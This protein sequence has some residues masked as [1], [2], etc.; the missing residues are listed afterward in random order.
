MT[1]P[2]S[3]D[4]QITTTTDSIIFPDG[5]VGCQ[6]WKNF[7]LLT[8]D[9]EEELPVAVLQSLDDPAVRLMVTDPRLLEPSF[10]PELSAEDYADL[11]LD[12]SSQTV[13]YC[14]LS[15]ADGW[16]TAN[17]LGPLVLNP[18]SRRGKQIVVVDSTFSTRYRI[19]PLGSTGV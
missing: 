2:I 6:D 14:T 7:I 5:L 9:G 18:I 10:V 12:E 15:T 3:T 17:L 19:A 8:D 1:A 16:L 4:N 11:G 13:M